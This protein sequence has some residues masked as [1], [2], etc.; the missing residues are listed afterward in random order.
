MKHKRIDDF[1]AL[2]GVSGT[3][4]RKAIKTGRIPPE[5]LG[6]RRLRSGR[7][8]TVIA[9]TAGARS[10]FCGETAE[11]QFQH[12]TA[13]LKRPLWNAD[14]ITLMVWDE[15]LFV[16]KVLMAVP[17]R[18][19]ESV[20][21]CTDTREIQEIFEGAIRDA[22]DDLTSD[23]DQFYADDNPDLEP[24]ASASSN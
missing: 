15:Y 20:A 10:A 7:I 21:A 23:I 8:V 18:V 11:P 16:R 2:I 6:H 17:A 12:T 24:D 9:N 1:A 19:A 13:Q 5:V 22:L 3:A 14:E 4:V